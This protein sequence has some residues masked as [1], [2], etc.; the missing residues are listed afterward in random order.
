MQQHKFIWLANNLKFGNVTQDQSGNTTVELRSQI[1]LIHSY[2]KKNQIAIVFTED[3]A[4]FLIPSE[5]QLKDIVHIHTNNGS[6]HAIR[7]YCINNLE[8][9]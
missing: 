9:I 5:D 7:E 1:Q 6:E 8:K 2:K 4:R 3:Q